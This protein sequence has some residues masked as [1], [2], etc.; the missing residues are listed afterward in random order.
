MP[1]P[2]ID[3]MELKKDLKKYKIIDVREPDEFAESHIEGA[4]N[5]PLGK[6]IRDEGKGIIPRDKEIIVHCKSGFRGQI[7]ADL[8]LQRGYN[9]KNLE[10]GYQAWCAQ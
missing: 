2:L 8:L 6:L 10:G 1:A 5:I 9:V 3:A 7:A 4:E